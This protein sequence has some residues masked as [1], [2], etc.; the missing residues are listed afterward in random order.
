MG[1][2]CK[3]GLYP[4]SNL[5][6]TL[7]GLPGKATFRLFQG[8]RVSSSIGERKK[9]L[10]TFQAPVGAGQ[11]CGELKVVRQGCHYEVASS[12]CKGSTLSY[13]EGLETGSS[14][15]NACN[16]TFDVFTLTSSKPSNE[17]SRVPSGNESLSTSTKAELL[18]VFDTTYNHARKSVKLGTLLTV[19]TT[20][21]H[22]S[23]FEDSFSDHLR[24]KSV[25]LKQCI[26][27]IV[28]LVHGKKGSKRDRLREHLAASVWPV[29]KNA[30]VPNPYEEL[31][32]RNRLDFEWPSF[33]H[34]GIE[35]IDDINFQTYKFG[36][37]EVLVQ[38]GPS[39]YKPPRL[40]VPDSQ[41]SPSEMIVTSL[42]YREREFETILESV[43]LTEDNEFLLERIFEST[44][45]PLSFSELGVLNHSGHIEGILSTPDDESYT[46]IEMRRWWLNECNHPDAEPLAELTFIGVEDEVAPLMDLS[47]LKEVDEEREG[48]L[49]S[50]THKTD[51]GA[52]KRET[53][54]SECKDS[55]LNECCSE[56]RAGFGERDY[57]S[58]DV[59]DSQQSSGS[60]GSQDGTPDIGESHDGNPS[61]RDSSHHGDRLSFSV[62]QHLPDYRPKSRLNLLTNF[63]FEVEPYDA[64]AVPWAHVHERIAKHRAS[65]SPFT[66][67][68][69]VSPAVT[70]P[71]RIEPPAITTTKSENFKSS[72]SKLA[73]W[74]GFLK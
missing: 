68:S 21:V 53:R 64:L 11:G 74:G 25:G 4:V 70:V 45:L 31:A 13:V 72:F 42:S 62:S 54:S 3:T 65:L 8:F 28:K 71:P 66:Q 16:N 33:G 35:V 57:S 58:L 26:R 9:E 2:I 32:R 22:N 47:D 34:A 27:K 20:M 43:G 73:S 38:T 55:P 46:D 52:L 30:V 50:Y 15:P 60:D 37:K 36:D 17:S 14:L 6:F 51:V 56:R 29:E 49:A 7:I 5:M 67:I 61:S 44:E 1:V 59:G 40:L 23:F 63:V 18:S 48:D 10:S 41:G 69:T 19:D 24:S 12:E 39:N